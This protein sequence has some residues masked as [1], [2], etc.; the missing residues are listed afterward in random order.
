MFKFK[1]FPDVLEVAV[2][3]ERHGADF[4]NKL[5]SRL[6]TPPAKDVFSFLAAQEEKHAGVLRQILEKVA[7]YAPRFN[8][9]GEYG[10]F[11]EGVA[12][13]L[14]DKI[15]KAM[16][17]LPTGNENEILDIGIEFEKETILFYQE[18]KSESKLS[19]KEDKVLQKVIDGERSHWQKLISL[20]NKLKF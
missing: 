12:S 1:N 20:K 3:I 11:I 14:L 15:E 16:V 9:P 13:S 6:E 4:Y 18:I 19:Q 5:S 8:Y 10:L 7:D 2:R 17:S